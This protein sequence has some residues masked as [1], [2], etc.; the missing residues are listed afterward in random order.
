MKMMKIIPI[1]LIKIF[2]N[3]IL[4]TDKIQV[5]FILFKNKILRFDNIFKT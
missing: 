1:K 2:L 4:F 5:N 3:F